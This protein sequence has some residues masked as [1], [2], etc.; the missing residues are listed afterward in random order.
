MAKIFKNFNN[1]FLANSF[2]AHSLLGLAI[3]GSGILGSAKTPVII[4]ADL[5]KYCFYYFYEGLPKS[6][7]KL[8]STRELARSKNENII[9]LWPL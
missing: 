4:F 9:L 6:L 7:R 3:L 8:Y 5:L 1:F 2:L